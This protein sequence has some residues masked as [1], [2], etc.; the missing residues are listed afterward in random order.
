MT[1]DDLLRLRVSED[2]H[3]PDTFFHPFS[4]HASKYTESL[5]FNHKNALDIV[6]SRAGTTRDEGVGE[7]AFDCSKGAREAKRETVGIVKN[8]HCQTSAFFVPFFTLRVGS[9]SLRTVVFNGSASPALGARTSYIV[10]IIKIPGKL[11]KAFRKL[12]RSKRNCILGPQSLS[13]LFHQKIVWSDR[14]SIKLLSIKSVEFYTL[15]TSC[16]FDLGCFQVICIQK[17]L[18]VW[19]LCFILMMKLQMYFFPHRGRIN[20][21]WNY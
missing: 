13:W 10:T 16:E 12:R 5:N 7:S 11:V 3:P 2:Q 8:R 19:A 17:V 9:S 1:L 6:A 4:T 15:Q 20:D 14:H 18:I 21:F